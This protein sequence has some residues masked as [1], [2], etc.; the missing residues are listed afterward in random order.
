MVLDYVG[1]D[2]SCQ[3]LKFTPQTPSG[4]L[5]PLPQLETFVPNQLILIKFGKSCP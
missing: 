1:I 2:Y 5:P 3:N 4:G